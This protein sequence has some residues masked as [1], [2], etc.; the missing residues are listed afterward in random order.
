MLVLVSRLISCRQ[1]ARTSVSTRSRL[2]IKPLVAIDPYPYLGGDA[3]TWPSTTQQMTSEHRLAQ[4]RAYR[5]RRKERLKDDPAAADHLRHVQR[6][7]AARARAKPENRIK[8]NARST[9]CE[10][11][12]ISTCISLTCHH[13][14]LTLKLT[15]ANSSTKRKILNTSP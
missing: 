8:I 6:Q 10:T 15:P 1:T 12:I 14:F 7:N 11:S 9:F 4:Y 5:A 13:Y 2:T 3:S